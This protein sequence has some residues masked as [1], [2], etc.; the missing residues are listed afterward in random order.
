MNDTKV[1]KFVTLATQ[2]EN[3]SS[4]PK[5]NQREPVKCEVLMKFMNAVRDSIETG[6]TP[7][8][9]LVGPYI[10]AYVSDEVTEVSGMKMWRSPIPLPEGREII[11]VRLSP[12]TARE[13]NG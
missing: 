3:Q 7:N 13:E 5:A 4:Y 1:N 2:N 11:A 10:S 12:T 8:W 6:V 9:L